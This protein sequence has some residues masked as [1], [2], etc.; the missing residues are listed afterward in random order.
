MIGDY[1]GVKGSS[2]GWVGVAG[3]VLAVAVAACD[4]GPSPAEVAMACDNYCEKVVA[5]QC[6][7]GFR[8]DLA[9]CKADNCVD[10]TGRSADCRTDLKGYYDC[11]IAQPDICE[12][13]TCMGEAV[14]VLLS[15][16]TR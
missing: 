15:C 4:T 6:P 12:E 3:L 9:M 16:G 5:A 8:N 13:A 14:V 7:T 10:A 11:L 1:E 2:L